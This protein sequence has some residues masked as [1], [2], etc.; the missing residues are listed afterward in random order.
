MRFRK[1]GQPWS[2]HSTHCCCWEIRHMW[3]LVLNSSILR[4]IISHTHV[5][6]ARAFCC[7]EF[8]HGD[9]I[10]I[11]HYLFKR[12][13]NWVLQTINL[14]WFTCGEAQF[15][16][17]SPWEPQLFHFVHLIQRKFKSTELIVMWL[18]AERCSVCLATYSPIRSVRCES[19][20]LS[21]YSVVLRR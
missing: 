14:I 2:T 13:S 9:F 15:T 8:I 4:I 20:P 7:G 11:L 21:L 16:R 10:N 12:L 5:A 17:Q 18:T 3:I 1:I 19:L 6:S